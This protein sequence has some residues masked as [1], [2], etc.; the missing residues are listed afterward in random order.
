MNVE[1]IQLVNS[2]VFTLES[3]DLY[4]LI[5]HVFLNTAP[6]PTAGS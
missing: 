1:C 2:S 4:M 3:R 6:G 5:Q